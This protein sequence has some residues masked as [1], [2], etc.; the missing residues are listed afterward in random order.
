[1]RCADSDGPS[2]RSGTVRRALADSLASVQ[3]LNLGRD[4]AARPHRGCWYYFTYIDQVP[5]A[6]ILGVLEGQ[7]TSTVALFGGA[8]EEQSLHR[9]A[10]G[11]WSLREVVSHLND[12]ERLFVFRALW[13]AP[14]VRQ[15]FAKLQSGGRDSEC[16]RGRT[17]TEQPC[18]RVPQ[19]PW[20]YTDVLSR[21]ASRRMDAP[22]HGKRQSVHGSGARVHRRGAHHPS[23]E[24]R[25]ERY[26][27]R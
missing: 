27:N 1:M 24:E 16:R 7:L 21:P 22:W 10:P 17:S 8:S 14:G 20:R 19:R 6:D 25:P 3:A 5:P 9:Y 11:K 26:L 23:R 13:F 18:R 15:S 2:T 4:H 12:T